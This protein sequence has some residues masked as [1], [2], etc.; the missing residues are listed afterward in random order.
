M[1]IAILFAAPVAVA[2]AQI[3][4]PDDCRNFCTREYDPICGSDGVTYSNRCELENVA[5]KSPEVK[6][7]YEGECKAKIE[8]PNF[9]TRELMPLCGSDGVTYS[10]RCHWESVACKS[11][12]V[13]V[14]YEGRC[15]AKALRA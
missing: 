14:A 10:N 8:C 7:A 12:E 1:K 3:V 15:K 9:C 2:Q 4:F 5:C 13:K 11:P 6:V